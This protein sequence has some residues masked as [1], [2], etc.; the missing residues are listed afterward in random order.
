MGSTPKRLQEI[1]MWAKVSPAVFLLVALSWAHWYFVLHD[2]S[3]L[4]TVQ[5]LFFLPLFMASLLFGLKGGLGCAVLL[6][7]NCLP[8]L[9][10][11]GPAV[12]DSMD[13]MTHL[14]LLFL[15]GIF[16]GALVDR[17]RRETGRR[18]KREEMILMGEAAASVAH[19]L[20]TPLVAIGGFALRMQRDL[21]DDH[22]HAEKLRIIVDQVAHMENM[23]RDMLYFTRPLELNLKTQAIGPLV[24]EAIALCSAVAEKAGVRLTTDIPDNPDLQ[25]SIDRARV[26]QVVINLLQNAVQASSPGDEVSVSMKTTS[27]KVKLRVHDQGAGVTQE[28]LEKIFNPFYTTKQRGTGLGLAISRR[29]VEAHGGDIKVNSGHGKGSTFEVVLPISQG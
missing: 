28:R 21:G 3:L 24:Q 27:S 15:T 18:R 19:E 11:I 22:P 6:S 17:E 7:L 29:I 25:P 23:L 2:P 5:R 14:G 26:L 4:P 12:Y 8:G 10:D 13:L 16:T 9:M 20:K 1:P